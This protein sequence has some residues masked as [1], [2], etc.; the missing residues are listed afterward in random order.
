M[1]YVTLKN[2]GFRAALTLVRA[3]VN[4]GD[5]E[6]IHWL[7][8]SKKS[9]LHCNLLMAALLKEAAP[10]EDQDKDALLAFLVSCGVSI[11]GS[12]FGPEGETWLSCLPKCTLSQRLILERH[13]IHETKKRFV[14][15]YEHVMV[16]RETM[17]RQCA[18]LL[19]ELKKLPPTEGLAPK[20][21]K[22][23]KIVTD[24]CDDFQVFS[25]PPHQLS[26]PLLK[27]ADLA[28]Q[29]VEL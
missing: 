15:G 16:H 27:G 1:N 2:Y 29:I 11:N 10:E 8:S 19:V 14:S 18:E 12:G 9:Q 23:A 5:M 3:Q 28:P 26:M 17:K 7:Y 24:Q 20:S 25:E 13:M 4:E 6:T 22:V 21:A